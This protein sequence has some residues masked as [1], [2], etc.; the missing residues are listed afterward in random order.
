[1]SR[2]RVFCNLLNESI[3]RD[4]P[5]SRDS[6]GGSCCYSL[7]VSD[8]WNTACPALGTLDYS[9]PMLICGILQSV[10]WI[11]WRNFT[12]NAWM[13]VFLIDWLNI[14]R[15]FLTLE[16]EDFGP[17]NITPICSLPGEHWR[18]RESPLVERMCAQEGVWLGVL[19]REAWS[20][21]R[22]GMVL[23]SDWRSADGVKC[24]E[25]Q[26]GCGERVEGVR[27]VCGGEAGNA[28]YK[29]NYMVYKVLDGEPILGRE[30][31]G[32]ERNN[33]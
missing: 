23:L 12:A 6:R 28:D 2:K 14:G 9:G 24:G 21:D 10:C 22:F 7:V 11:V 4:I 3:L 16:H 26:K 30:I 18:S 20:G 17:S 29:S 13:I 8:L 31:C 27:G 1:M 5:H 19:L 32:L 15:L 33:I 25:R